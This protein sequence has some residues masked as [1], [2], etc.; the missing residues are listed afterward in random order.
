MRFPW[1]KKEIRSDEIAIDY[2]SWISQALQFGAV[3]T[4]NTARSIGAVYRATEIISDAIAVLPIKIREVNSQHTED[5]SSHPVHAAFNNNLVTKYNLIKL[6]MES[7]ML[8]G[9]GFAYIKRDSK[10]VPTNIIFC[11]SETVTIKY[12]RSKQTLNYKVSDVPGIVQPKDIIHLVKNSYDGIQGQSILSFAS[13]SIKLANSAE[14]NAVNFFKNGCNLS[15]IL[16]VQGQLNSKQREDIHNSWQQAYGGNDGGSG[17]AVLQGNMQ[18]SPVS[19]NAADAQLLESRQFSVEDIARFFGISPV[20]LGDLSNSS[21]STIEAMQQDFLLHTLQPYIE[22]IEHE[23]NRKLI[24]TNLYKLT[25]DESYLMRTDKTAQAN[26]YQTL[27]NSG[28]LC[29]NEVRKDLGF[30]PIAGG[31]KHVIPFTNI[32]DNTI[33]NND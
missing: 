9:N 30:S 25:L 21:F 3:G 14:N 31:D 24:D 16:T 23:F 17:L 29:V 12:N 4:N 7:V 6:L 5:N 1:S 10:G 28:V 22:M 19:V 2:P 11:P 13:R 33:N 18:Y 32:E 20:L 8:H 26:Y 15:G 27:L